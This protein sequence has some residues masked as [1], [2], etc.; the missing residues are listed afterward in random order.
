MTFVEEEIVPQPV[1]P[2]PPRKS[3]K[4]KWKNKKKSATK[5]SEG[6]FVIRLKTPGS[7]Q[8]AE[9]M[10]EEGRLGSSAEILAAP[11]IQSAEDSAVLAADAASVQAD[12]F[13]R[14]IQ[15]TDE[16]Q[17]PT[18]GEEPIV[19]TVSA[20]TLGA[21]EVAAEIAPGPAATKLV[22]IRTVD[23]K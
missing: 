7:A 21:S 6:R 15:S 11:T 4:E 16:V 22:E 9:A 12:V 2:Q 10:E 5:E 13:D 23:E 19:E 1:A 20:P 14:P 18:E 3:P 17:P 8:S